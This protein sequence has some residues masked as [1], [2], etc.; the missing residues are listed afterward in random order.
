MSATRSPQVGPRV[1]LARYLI[2]TGE[3]V[4]YGQRVDGI[5][6]ITDRPAADRPGRAF[7]VKRGL[8]SHQAELDAVVAGFCQREPASGE[9]SRRPSFVS[10]TASSAGAPSSGG[11]RKRSGF[12][13]ALF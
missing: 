11:A 13:G 3:R 10:A 9:T 12:V 1:V 6:R 7:L 2:S 8:T 5:V 4:V